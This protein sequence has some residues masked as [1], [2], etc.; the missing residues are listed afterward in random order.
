MCVNG[1]DLVEITCYYKGGPIV[2]GDQF[3][4][5][6]V[7]VD[8]GRLSVVGHIPDGFV[9]LGNRTP[10]AARISTCGP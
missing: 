4:D 5:H 10:P 2:G 8:A 1:N 6:V 7:M 3:Q 9:D